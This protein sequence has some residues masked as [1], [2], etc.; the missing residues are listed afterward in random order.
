MNNVKYGC[1]A[2]RNKGTCT[3]RALIRRSEVEARVLEGL[4]EHLLHPDLIAEF[5]AEYQREYNQLMQSART[6]R[7]RLEKELGQVRRQI[8]QIV[9]AVANGMFHES[10]KTKLT[11]LEARQA[12]LEA[13]LAE[14]GEEPPIRLHPG[15]ADHYRAKVAD[16]AAA[17]D[18]PETRQEAAEAMRGLLTEIRMIPEDG[19]HA[20]ELVG[21][22]AGI[23]ALSQGETKAP[24][25]FGAGVSHS[26][27]AGVG[28]EPTTFRL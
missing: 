20:I 10:M 16:L 7:T 3:N 4:K 6:D 17:L 9:D 28:F 26:L 15:L 25:A 18:T 12:E 21:D 22:L 5:V 1:A 27:V 14:I 13:E 19:G 24:P 23:L 8:E 2:V 11:D